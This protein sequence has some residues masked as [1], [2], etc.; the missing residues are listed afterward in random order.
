M[1]AQRS[2]ASTTQ[3]LRGDAR[4]LRVDAELLRVPTSTPRVLRRRHTGREYSTSVAIDVRHD[5]ILAGLVPHAVASFRVAA[6]V[7]NLE[8]VARENEGHTAEVSAHERVIPRDAA[9]KLALSAGRRT[10]KTAPGSSAGSSRTTQAAR[11]RFAVR[12][13]RAARAATRSQS[14]STTCLSPASICRQVACECCASSGLPL[15]S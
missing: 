6:H 4:S 5:Q 1:F 7:A 3:L 9:R 12:A 15:L 11:V 8:L 14:A 13:A 10:T 2:P